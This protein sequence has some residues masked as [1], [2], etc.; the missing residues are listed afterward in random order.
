MSPQES[1]EAKNDFDIAVIGMS[2]RFPQAKNVEEFW[3]NLC[4]A[5][6]SVSFF[7]DEELI[8][9]GVDESLIKDPYYVKA[10]G[11]VDDIDKFDAQFFNFFP[12]EAELLDPQQRVFLECSYEALEDAGCNTDTYPGIIGVW[13][14][15]G[16]NT[17]LHPFLAS[18][19][20]V[21]TTSEGYQLSI[22]N[23]KDFLA[24]RVSYKLNLKGPSLDLQT[25]CSTSL[26]AI[27]NA[28]LNLL[29]YQ[30]D[31]ALAGG[32]TIFIPQKS[33]YLYQ[34]GMI[35]SPDGHCR[36]FDNDA[37]GTVGGNGCGI[38][39]L[40]RLNDAIADKDHIYAVIKAS[41]CNNDGADRVGYTAPGIE[42]QANVIATA[43]SL[44]NIDPSTIQYV[45]AHGTGTV[46]GDPIEISALTK[47]YREFTQEK[48]YCAIGSVKSNFGHLDAAAGVAGF[49]KTVLSL[50]HSKIPPSIN[51]KNYNTKIDF[52]SS[53]F[54]V[55]KDLSEWKNNSNAPRRA[56]V[57]SFG[58]GGTNAHVI[59]EE[60][61]KKESKIKILESRE[62][63]S[64]QHSHL[65]TLSAKS[66]N[67][68]KEQKEKLYEYIKN[69]QN[70]SE[71]DLEDVAFTLQTG[72]KEYNLRHAFVARSFQEALDILRLGDV[73][74]A[75]SGKVS[76][77][78]VNPQIAFMFTGQGS[79]YAAMGR[80]IYENE[81]TYSQIVD[82]CSEYLKPLL[83]IDLRDVLL[84]DEK[85]IEQA[86]Y[87]IDQTF[88]TQP[89]LFVVQYALSR[90]FISWGI[91]PTI[92]VGHSIGEYTAACLSG[93]ISLEDT[94]RLVALRGKLMQSMPAGAMTG[95]SINETE[96]KNLLSDAVSVAAIN[97]PNFL[98][99]SGPFEA[100][101][102]TEQL[103]KEK[104]I[105]FRRLHTSHAFHSAMM[106]PVLRRFE[107]EVK[108]IKL[109][110]P[111]I[112][113]LSNVSGKIITERDAKDPAY[114]GRHLR[115]TVRFS[116]NM[117]E[118]L[119]LKGITLLEIGPGNTLSSFARSHSGIA[120][121]NII[122]TIR[123]PKEERNDYS[124]LLSSLARLWVNGQKINWSE[125]HKNSPSSASK[126]SLPTYPFERKR[127]WLDLKDSHF[128]KQQSTDTTKRSIE[129]WFYTPSWKRKNVILKPL[130]KKQ[131]WLILAAKDEIIDD[132][133]KDELFKDDQIV[134][135]AYS[136]KSFKRIDETSFVVNPRGEEDLRKLLETM[137][138]EDTFPENILVLWNIDRAD[139]DEVSSV[140]KQDESY[141]GYYSLVTLAKA[142]SQFN[143]K[144]PINISSVTL[145]MFDVADNDI[146]QPEERTIIGPV[147]V[148]PQEYPSLKCKIIDLEN[149]NYNESLIRSILNEV[150]YDPKDRIVSCRGK[151]K[152]VQSFESFQ[153]TTG[154]TA[155]ESLLRKN[156]VYLITGGLGRIGFKLTE[157][158]SK[159]FLAKVILTTVDSFP[160]KK[161]WT[162]WLQTHPA[163][164][165]VSHKIK[166]LKEL[167]SFGAEIQV[168]KADASNMKEMK[169]IVDTIIE[170]YGEL[171]GVFHLAGQ[172]GEK[173]I[174]PIS[175]L[176]DN[177]FDD[178]IKPK[179]EGAKV[180]KEVLKRKRADFVFL[181]SS[182]ST[183]AGGIGLT[184]YSA[185]NS[186]LDAFV[187]KVNKSS[188]TRWISVAWDGW[189][190]LEDETS[191]FI[192]GDSLIL[193]EEGQ[194]AFKL[195]LNL[196]A[197]SR[198]VISK[199]DL[200]K[201]IIENLTHSKIA[202]SE[203]G[204]NELLRKDISII[205][206]EHISLNGNGNGSSALSD[207]SLAG[208]IAESDRPELATE[209][210]SPS[211]ELE[212]QILEVWRELLGINKIGRNDSFFDLGGNSLLGTQLITKLR[213][214]FKC[215]L[216]LKSLFQEPT[217]AGIASVIES[218]RLEANFNISRVDELLKKV[219]KLSD[220]EVLKLLKQKNANG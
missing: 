67:A 198:I 22:G 113:Y 36:P 192:A 190:F 11:I 136:G 196:Y 74:S 64:S 178:Q 176:T 33:G 123:H 54:Y 162:N 96:V 167:E 78:T 166:Q 158:L 200:Q 172:V 86:S 118:I 13:G 80:G 9:S 14:G 95:V 87:Q 144:D 117:Q 69:H 104:Q 112:P 126:V 205:E 16:M 108:K 182:L 179:I 47:V 4:N 20:K 189:K 79:Q 30:C 51:F 71:L 83:S 18:K 37:K 77:D 90:L 160:N 53:P 203:K 216:P 204:T 145:N 142:L 57:S 188:I 45:E 27:H 171:N 125:L 60:A 206:K 42:G 169:E 99:L 197:P 65:L 153:I 75:F 143:L 149:T 92:M 26:V 201:R 120:P 2:C 28:C 152:W 110:T 5:K 15:V 181:M 35:L 151:Y 7:S 124:F 31:C 146:S 17:Y 208:S 38:V 133:M 212:N 211:G 105:D 111:S 59:L 168:Y 207:S 93:V 98:T 56:A 134:T 88:I 139:Y 107:E 202:L 34:E 43:L 19:P 115:S 55:A 6:E 159:D 163:E 101:Q 170:T 102:K 209:Y 218:Q 127:Y 215:E 81:K 175:E 128:P 50:Y 193:P 161:R 46:L 3:E 183:V 61:P 129:D 48:N 131:K 140:E 49:M 180:L 44:A 213:Q 85:F 199:T 72:R 185:A 39:V 32:S 41:A 91:N 214:T 164:D 156:G 174:R 73:K 137:K 191:G 116:E 97:S 130:I 40:K 24:T 29:N 109:N 1:Y 210:A 68:L 66:T 103:L 76:N 62:T 25:A 121:S 100:I 106:D 114:Y 132:F 157:V 154:K 150:V 21:I 141:M 177:D 148:I 184:A 173:A 89:A 23:E 84:P 194:E 217:I 135:T 147:N 165:P 63:S 8:E 219:S 52:H 122:S 82:Y 138:N 70:S 195:A 186:F 155:S 12:K 220:E 119:K 94:L 10:R 187:L 58:I